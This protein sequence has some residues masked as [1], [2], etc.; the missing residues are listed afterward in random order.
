[1]SF[2]MADAFHLNP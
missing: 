2:P 1:M